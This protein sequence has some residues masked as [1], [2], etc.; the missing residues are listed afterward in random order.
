MTNKSTTYFRDGIKNLSSY[1]VQDAKGLIKLDAMEAPYDISAGL[2]QKYLEKIEK[3]ELNRYP[4]PEVKAL[5]KII[6][7]K[8][9][10]ID[11]NGILFG[12]GSDELIQLLC[13]SCT[14]NDVIMGFNPS[15]IMYDLIAQSTQLHYEP[16]ALDG[17]YQI[18]IAHSLKLIAKH[19]PKIIFIA[20]PNNPTGNLFNK[21]DIIKII[22]NTDYLVVLDEAY[23]IYASDNFLSELNKY[24]NLI[25]IRTLSKLGLAGIRLGFLIANKDIIQQLNKLRLPY[26]INSLTQASA[27][28]FLTNDTQIKTH[29][30]KII[31]SR[32]A[33]VIAINKINGLNAF[34]SEANF[35]LFKTKNPDK[36]FNYLLKNKVLIKNLS[37]HKSLNNHLRVSIGT[38]YENK[39][40]INLLE[41][42]A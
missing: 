36:L 42:F 8:F 23:Y 25:I 39:I 1:K 26:N 38:S 15:F 21:Q 35:I 10:I 9:N 6:K 4:D 14:A 31:A 16:I 32:D 28:F 34:K 7:T 5:N 41:T 12:S 24:P 19:K 22:K 3:V 18:N 40:F 33:M 37:S 29:I 27:E 11:N 2:K 20:Y 17:N 13:M 30:K